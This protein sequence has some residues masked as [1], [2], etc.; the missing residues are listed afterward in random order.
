MKTSLTV[1]GW[2]HAIVDPT[3]RSVI[4]NYLL[5]IIDIDVTNVTVSFVSQPLNRRSLFT[6]NRSIKPRMLTT[7]WV[8]EATYFFYTA[9]GTGSDLAVT[10]DSNGVDITDFIA[11]LNAACGCSDYSLITAVTCKNKVLYDAMGQPAG[12]DS[13]HA[14]L[15]LIAL[16]ALGVFPCCYYYYIKRHKKEASPKVQSTD[17]EYKVDF[18]S[19]SS[20]RSSPSLV[21]RQGLDNVVVSGKSSSRRAA[22]PEV[23]DKKVDSSKLFNS[24]KKSGSKNKKISGVSRT[25]VPINTTPTETE[26]PA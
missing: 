16:L 23:V 22:S 8:I 19:Y 14:S 7:L 9:A 26:L 18:A 3:A 17:A 2:P 5:D 25:S 6:A 4:L 10:L 1:S 15:A 13:S 12:G 24:A 11:N 20:S 21:S